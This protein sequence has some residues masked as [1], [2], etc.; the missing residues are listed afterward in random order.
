MC[1]LC[2]MLFSRQTSMKTHV[3]GHSKLLQRGLRSL[4]QQNVHVVLDSS[5]MCVVP[6]DDIERIP[7]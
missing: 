1:E 2:G 6:V 7:T 4:G 5:K 3:A